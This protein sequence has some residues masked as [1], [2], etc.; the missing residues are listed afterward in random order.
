MTN[1]SSNPEHPKVRSEIQSALGILVF[2]STNFHLWLIEPKVTQGRLYSDI[3]SKGLEHPWILVA[4]G[5]HGTNPPWTARDNCT[6][7]KRCQPE[8]L[9]R[10]QTPVLA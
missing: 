5:C 1:H 7:K 6:L 4:V 2:A 9:Q 10:L 3:L 8:Q